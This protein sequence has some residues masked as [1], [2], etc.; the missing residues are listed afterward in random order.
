MSENSK[1][2]SLGQELMLGESPPTDTF[3]STRYTYDFLN[4]SFPDWYKHRGYPNYMFHYHYH[5]FLE[6]IFLHTG[7]IKVIA[8]FGKFTLKEGEILVVNSNEVHSGFFREKDFVDYTVIL[9]NIR[10]LSSKLNSDQRIFFKNLITGKT[11]I[12]NNITPNT[13]GYDALADVIL[14]TAN[15]YILN[16]KNNSEFMQIGS[17]ISVLSA[18]EDCGVIC[19]TP[20]NPQTKHKDFSVQALNYIQANYKTKIT[21]KNA[22]KFFAYDEAQ[23]CRLFKK[24]FNMTF[25]EF[26]NFY[27]IKMACCYSIS[28][29][30]IT[31]EDI[32]K[33]VGYDN[34]SYFCRNFKK[35]TGKTPKEF[36]HNSIEP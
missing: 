9:I 18:I 28:D 31:I 7:R 8:D 36:F 17:A 33:E 16:K 29:K 15:R 32:A 11:R 10:L 24:H 30:S 19:T 21:T 4:N 1:F 13:D 25:I 22:S 35:H 5:E 6:I 20:R 14:H 2:F 23:F 26:L 27:R 3:Y 12:K 34:Y